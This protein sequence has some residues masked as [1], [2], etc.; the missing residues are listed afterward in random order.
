MATLRHAFLTRPLG[1]CAGLVHG[2]FHPTPMPS[3]VHLNFTCNVV[4]VRRRAVVDTFERA[5]AAFSRPVDPA[6]E[7]GMQQVREGNRQDGS[8]EARAR[9]AVCSP[10]GAATA[11]GHDGCLPK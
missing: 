3:H 8:R 5:I 11:A 6:I 10:L 7:T 1:Q 9:L 2:Q 4:L